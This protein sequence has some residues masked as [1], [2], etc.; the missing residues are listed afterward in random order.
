MDFTG[1]FIN[2]N[3]SNDFIKYKINFLGILIKYIFL[4]NFLDIKKQISLRLKISGPERLYSSL[5]KIPV[6]EKFLRIL[7]I[8]N[9]ISCFIYDY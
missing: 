2:F 9:D 8:A 3:I 5:F 1:N 6:S 4:F 7:N